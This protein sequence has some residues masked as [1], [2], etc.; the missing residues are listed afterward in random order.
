MTWQPISDITTKFLG[1]PNRGC[2]DCGTIMKYTTATGHTAYYPGVECCAPALRRQIQWRSGDID[3]LQRQ[4]QT[5]E[6]TVQQI[7]DE[8][9]HAHS[10]TA[11]A[12]AAAK[13]E[14]AERNLDQA[15]REIYTP[16]LR[17]L[18]AE[19]ARLRRKLEKHDEHAKTA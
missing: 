14:R 10:R 17:E 5:R 12:A 1:D 16:Q 13:K 19:I 6:K 8:I 4:L 3:T 15:M 7:Q 18:S 2:R 9:D 11:A